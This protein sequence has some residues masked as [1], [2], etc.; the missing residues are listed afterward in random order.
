MTTAFKALSLTTP[1]PHSVS[2]ADEVDTG[3]TSVLFFIDR[4][5]YNLLPYLGSHDILYAI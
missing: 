4:A 3:I 1:R 2:P 5:P